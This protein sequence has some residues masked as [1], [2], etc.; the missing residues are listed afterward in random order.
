[1]TPESGQ[2]RS[3]F[4]AIIGRPNVGKSTLLNSLVGEKIAITS[5]RP[6]TTR[7]RII[8]IRTVGDQQ[9]IFVDTPGV[10]DPRT[11]LGR[12]MVDVARRSIPDS[13]VVVWVVDVSRLPGDIESRVASWIKRAGVPVILAMN[14]SDLL[15]PEDIVAHTEAYLG[16]LRVDDW[17]LT[18]ATEA[19]N[20]DLLWDMIAR[21]LPPGPFYY[22]QDQ[23][24]DQT[25]RMLVAEL[26]REAALRYLQQEVPHGVEVVVDS[27]EEEDDGTLRIEATVIV[28]RESHVG[29]VVGRGGSMI[30]RIGQSARRE[31]EELLDR[32][33]YLGLRVKA[34]PGWRRR[35]PEVRRLGY[36]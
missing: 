23:L 18:I 26:V 32:H 7:R 31:I 2:T 27:W 33:V 13:D 22:P 9:A 25:D 4:V 16:L 6:Q 19:H 36:S 28:E 15:A 20:L 35:A 1:M 34:R 10:H 3:G 29:I 17:V 24:T 12:Y 11:D 14:K 5:H 21:R 8:G 30:K